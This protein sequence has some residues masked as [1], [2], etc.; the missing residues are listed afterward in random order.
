MPD[1]PGTTNQSPATPAPEAAADTAADAAAAAGLPNTAVMQKSNLYLNRFATRLDYPP[2]AFNV[3]YWGGRPGHRGNAEHSHTFLEI[4]Y[5]AGGE[6]SYLNNGVRYPLK[7]GTLYAARPGSRHRF[8]SVDGMVLWFVAFDMDRESSSPDSCRMY[9]SLCE[10]EHLF[11]PNAG[12]TAVVHL[13]QSLVLLSGDADAPPDP[14]VIARIAHSL[15]YA[16]IRFFAERHGSLH[17]RQSSDSIPAASAALAKAE[18]Y[19]QER[20]SRKLTLKEVAQA[21]YLSERQ[22]SRTIAEGLGQT[23]PVWLRTERVRRAAY[24]LAYTDQSISRIAEDTG[25]DTISYFNRVFVQTL[26]ITPGKFRKQAGSDEQDAQAV[27]Q[28][29]LHLLVARHKKQ[30]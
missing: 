7:Q 13:W 15:L 29:Y 18:R 30:P 27:M 17:Q 25:F 12:Q 4:C 26:G 11:L 16:A 14:D 5:V 20:L 19:I 24:L 28:Q 8:E 23:F 2:S 3:R 10:L 1:M 9:E 21:L 22:L 6:G